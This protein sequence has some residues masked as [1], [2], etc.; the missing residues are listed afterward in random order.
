MAGKSLKAAVAA[1]LPEPTPTASSEQVT[2]RQDGDVL[3]AKS[4]SRRIK[5]VEDLLRHIEADLQRYEVSASE[6][7]KWE[8]GTSDGEGGTTVTEL[9]RVFVRL[10]PKAG[11]SVQECVEAMITAAAKKLRVPAV[12]KPPRRDGLWQVLPIGD[13]HY[14]KYAWRRTT[15]GGDYDLDIAGLRSDMI[16]VEKRLSTIQKA[17]GI[18]SDDERSTIGEF[19]KWIMKSREGQKFVLAGFAALTSLITALGT[20]YALATGRL[21]MPDSPRGQVIHEQAPAASP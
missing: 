11:P 9:H 2:Q 16:V 4:T 18:K 15:G 12:K 14:G 21:P 8:V 1:A 3:E 20:V 13:P 10:R 17:M 7:T 5:T 19:F 6:A